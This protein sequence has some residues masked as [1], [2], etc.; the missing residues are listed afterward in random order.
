MLF[1]E[2]L[3]VNPIE[4]PRLKFASAFFAA[5]SVRN[6]ERATLRVFHPNGFLLIRVFIYMV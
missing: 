6:G 2:D 4:R 5:A 1:K 3:R